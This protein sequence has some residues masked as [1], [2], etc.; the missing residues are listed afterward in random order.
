MGFAESL[1]YEKKSHPSKEL[2]PLTNGDN[3]NQVM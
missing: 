1:D 3:P 2:E